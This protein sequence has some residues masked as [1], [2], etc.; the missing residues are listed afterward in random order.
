[1][2]NFQTIKYPDRMAT[3]PK[4]KSLD[5]EKKSNVPQEQI[6]NLR[7]F[8]KM[9]FSA[10]QT[11]NKPNTPGRQTCQKYFRQWNEQI[12]KEYDIE[13][14]ER[15]ILAKQKLRIAFQRLLEKLEDQLN[16]FENITTVLFNRWHSEN[17]KAIDEKKYTE[18][19]EYKPNMNAENMK[20]HLIGMI[21]EIQDAMAANET[22]PTIMEEAESSVI[23]RIKKKTEKVLKK[24]YETKRKLKKSNKK[25]E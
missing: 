15:Q 11:S 9:G 4:H 8:W 3:T 12:R 18:I 17:K 24:G 25:L 5:T 16:T 1:M 23:T 13:T 2:K 6:D 21:A 10:E 22:A 19:K 20:R 7:D 14:N